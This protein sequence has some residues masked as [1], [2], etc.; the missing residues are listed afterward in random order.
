MVEKNAVQALVCSPGMTDTR[1]FTK[2]GLVSTRLVFGKLTEQASLSF[3]FGVHIL[4]LEDAPWAHDFIPEPL[5]I[6]K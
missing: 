3:E 1:I 5:F 2:S 4:E 6:S